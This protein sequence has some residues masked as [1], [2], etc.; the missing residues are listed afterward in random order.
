MIVL[1]RLRT[2]NVADF[3]ALLRKEFKF[4]W[5]LYMFNFAIVIIAKAKLLKLIAAPRIQVAVLCQDELIR[6]SAV[7]LFYRYAF[8]RR[9]LLRNHLILL[10]ILFA[11]IK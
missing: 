11:T 5:L 4:L 3:Y 2:R 9:K 10:A 1:Y 7:N 6:L 8:Q